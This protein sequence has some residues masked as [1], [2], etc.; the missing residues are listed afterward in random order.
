MNTN[1]I[2]N[3]GD[4]QEIKAHLDNLSRSGMW[5]IPDGPTPPV[6]PGP[7]GI[8]ELWDPETGDYLDKVA[9]GDW[10]ILAFGGFMA[11]RHELAEEQADD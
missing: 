10:L 2:Q 5:R 3:T 1:A 6:S 4:W 8:L 9:V 11:V 7:A